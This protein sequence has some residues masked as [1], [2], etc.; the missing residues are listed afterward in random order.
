MAT[1]SDRDK[2]L[3]QNQ[4]VDLTNQNSQL[5]DSISSDIRQINNLTLLDIPSKKNLDEIHYQ[6]FQLE[7]ERRLLNGK[8]II[9]PVQEDSFS[10]TSTESNVTVTINDG[11]FI[12]KKNNVTMVDVPIISSRAYVVSKA[13]G[14]DFELWT[15]DRHGSSTSG[16][17]VPQSYLIHDAN[18][19]IKVTIDGV[20]REV[21]IFS[22]DVLAS[23]NGQLTVDATVLSSQISLSLTDA[24]FTDARCLYNSSIKAFTIASGTGGTNSTVNV[25]IESVNDIAQTMKFNTQVT[26]AGRYSNNKLK[27]NIDGVEKQ[28]EF[29][30]GDIRKPTFNATLGYALDDYSAD[31]LFDFSGSSLQPA[32]A[33]NGAYFAN[34]IQSKLRESFANVE[35]YYYSNSGQFIIYSGT[36]GL[37]SS[38][39]I[40]AASD[41]N[42]DL[43]PFIGMD[44]PSETKNNETAYTTVQSL[45]NFINSS[46]T[47]IASNIVNPT[48]SCY[49]LLTINSALI[50]NTLLPLQTTNEYDYAHLGQ[51]RL[52]GNKT[53]I[54]S[55]NNT[56]DI[57]E[58]SI[59]TRT[60]TTGLFSESELATYIQTALNVGSVVYTVQYNQITKQFVITSSIS[61]TFLFNSGANKSTSIATYIGFSNTSDT[62][63]TSFTSNTISFAGADF[64]SMASIPQLVMVSW[65]SNKPPYYIDSSVQTESNLYVQ[66]LVFL[67]AESAASA[68]LDLLQNQSDVFNEIYLNHWKNVA[69]NEL[70]YVN[71]L[72]AVIGRELASY[73]VISTTDSNY[74]NLTAALNEAII[75]RNDLIAKQLNILNLQLTTMSFDSSLLPEAGTDL[76]IIAFSD[77]NGEKIYDRP[78]V[79]FKYVTGNKYIPMKYVNPIYSNNVSFT[80]Q[81]QTGFTIKSTRTTYLGNPITDVKFEVTPTYISSEIYW[82][83]GSAE[84]FHIDFVSC[85]DVKALYDAIDSSYYDKSLVAELWSRYSEKYTIFDGESFHLQ[86]GTGGSQTKTF[87]VTSGTSISD[88]NPATSAVA[89]STLTLSINGEYYETIT[90]A[91]SSYSGTD[92]AFQIQSLVRNLTAIYYENQPAYSNFTCT[93]SAGLYTLTS[94][95][96]GSGSS[97]NVSGGTLKVPMKL[98]SNQTAGS[99]EFFNNYFVTIY[100]LMLSFTFTGVTVSNDSDFLKFSSNDKITI[101]ATDV[102][103]RLGFYDE[104]LISDPIVELQ[105]VDS[106]SLQRV[107]DIDINNVEYSVLRGYESRNGAVASYN[108]MNNVNLDDR[109]A[110]IS[111]RLTSIST[112]QSQIPTRIS[113]IDTSLTTTLYNSR[114]TQVVNRLNKKT[115][116]YYKVGE[117][118]SSISS[119]QS[120]I[121]SN[122]SKIIEIQTMLGV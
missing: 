47:L 15:R 110:I 95:T 91:T 20:T 31:W 40:L 82:S 49:S 114:W 36:F 5:Q 67:D 78:A 99:G 44:E 106:S 93:Y 113:A 120:T 65:L 101:F 108:V 85:P 119:T 79:E 109:R 90:L 116:S 73:S 103:T 50:S 59:V 10:L 92:L 107:S 33:N 25:V 28:L 6:I 11:R 121:L 9:G 17:N 62:T 76:V 87:S 12:A 27:V 1:L 122:D 16:I 18:N 56:I 58:G 66:E 35:C 68:A 105:T 48:K 96:Q 84:D 77:P 64:Y 4:I 43:A 41:S 53:R 30:Y 29:T 63:G 111:N 74:L 102:A 94:G 24:G 100:E 26:V 52:Y 46:T 86:I 13:A 22:D 72:I 54:T 37:S 57:N 51:P 71:Q 97:V 112:R 115:G 104:N 14:T 3:L 117:K 8:T 83:T 88:P 61:V 70:Y 81:Q 2:A 23:Q 69:I 98:G 80:L 118:E 60:I 45:Y 38:V 89:S 39:Q 34:I 7:D 75:N 42:R 55:S 21:Q 32:T 19:K